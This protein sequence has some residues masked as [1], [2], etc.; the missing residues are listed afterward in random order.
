MSTFALERIG[1]EELDPG[2]NFLQSGSWARLKER[3]GWEALALR[4]YEEGRTLLVLTRSFRGLFRLAYI[5]HAPDERFFDDSM[6]EDPECV[7]RRMAALARGVVPHLPRRTSVLRFDPRLP[8][9][10]NDRQLESNGLCK[11]PVDIQPPDTVVIDI[12]RS[13]EDLLSGMKSKW[14]YNVRLAAK[15]GVEVRA[16][17]DRSFAEDFARWYEIYRV[18]ARRDRIAIH[19]RKYYRDVL[20]LS[21]AHDSSTGGLAGELLLAEHE[22]ELL[23][24]IVTVRLGARATY[25][26]GASSD[27]KR[28]LMP[29][30]ALQWEA[31]R[32][33][34]AAGC[35]EYDMY[36]I[37]PA[38]DPKHPMHGLYRFKT[39]FGGQIVRYPGSIDYRFAPVAG[40]LFRHAE[41]LRDYYYKR[42]R[43]R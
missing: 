32:R 16:S 18:T 36:G 15:R 43:K 23:A 29:A 26:F 5:G 6:T 20:E 33:A 8:C 25:L 14:R 12:T 1:L 42:V 4:E 41:S 28:N 17:D 2:S 19:S 13:E 7:C 35:V 37:P 3:H 31:I 22:G 24:G 9:R 39:G 11:G 27:H 38:D 34:K 40:R 10:P 21:S 30:Y